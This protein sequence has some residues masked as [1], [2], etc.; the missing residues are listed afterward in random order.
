MGAREEATM[1][2][3][4]VLLHEDEK[5]WAAASPDE[6]SQAYADH[7]AFTAACARDGHEILGGLELQPAATSLLVRRLDGASVVSDGPYA[8]TVEQLGGY[9]VVST[10]DVRGLATLVGTLLSTGTA[11][12]RPAVDD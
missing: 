10:S 4:L 1:A 7:E 2:R 9:Y 3:Y 6:R 11:E 8:E 12:L 5:A